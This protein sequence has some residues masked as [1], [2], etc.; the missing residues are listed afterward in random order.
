MH[1]YKPNIIDIKNKRWDPITGAFSAFLDFTVD[2]P[3]AWTGVISRPVREYRT[4]KRAS[5]AS[6]IACS[7]SAIASAQP[8]TSVSSQYSISQS[9]TTS[10]TTNP[11]LAVPNN[12]AVSVR[13]VSGGNKE[14]GKEKEKTESASL[15]AGRE[16]GMSVGRVGIAIPKTLVDM[17]VALAEGCHNMPNIYGNEVR[18]FGAVEGFRSGGQKTMKVCLRHFQQRLR[19]HFGTRKH[20]LGTHTDAF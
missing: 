12:D 19:D 1:R 13:N 6:I 20:A 15:A 3:L 8:R 17:S 7:S 2:F 14:K 11:T 4:V 5:R 10:H 18:D 9:S 16:F